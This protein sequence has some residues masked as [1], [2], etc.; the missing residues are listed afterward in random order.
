MADLTK[1]LQA[2]TPPSDS[3]NSKMDPARLTL[4]QSIKLDWIHKSYVVYLHPSGQYED[5][6]EVLEKIPA[7]LKVIRHIRPKYAC[8]CCERIFQAAA[9][10]LSMAKGHSI[11]RVDELLPWNWQHSRVKLAA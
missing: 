4:P 6:T 7:P 5:A 11:N 1:R 8:R 3:L 9:P 2:H 10:D